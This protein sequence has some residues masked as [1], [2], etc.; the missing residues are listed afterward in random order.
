M[1][2]NKHGL[3]CSRAHACVQKKAEVVS[4][5]R[6]ASNLM[7]RKFTKAERQDTDAIPF[8]INGIFWFTDLVVLAIAKMCLRLS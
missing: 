5:G 2:D 3:I 4:F 7:R 1:L 8:P 6:A